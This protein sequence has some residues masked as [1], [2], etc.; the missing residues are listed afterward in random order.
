METCTTDMTSEG[1][2]TLLQFFTQTINICYFLSA[3]IW[4]QETN[5]IISTLSQSSADV[6][7][8]MKMSSSLQ[9]SILKK[10]SQTVT[11]QDKLLINGNLLLHTLKESLINAHNIYEEFKQS[12][13]EQRNVIFEIFD[14][15]V[16]LSFGT[17]HVT[18]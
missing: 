11:N 18:L 9:K 7:K 6:A 2:N 1:Y 3:Q 12:T 13:N 10:Q 15:Y 14:R 8:L 17:L 16:Q 4:Q 5:N